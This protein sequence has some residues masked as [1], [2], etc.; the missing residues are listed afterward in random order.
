[1]EEDAM[2]A[3]G[4]FADDFPVPR[5]MPDEDPDGEDHLSTPLARVA[6]PGK[7]ST[8]KAIPIES[9]D[10]DD[11]DCQILDVIDARPLNCAPQVVPGPAAATKRVETRK[12]AGS[13]TAHA[14]GSGAATKKSKITT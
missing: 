8:P 1:M 7:P 10:D 12:R 6:A 2:D 11:D 14:G 3:E 9:D 4:K 5:V 13:Q